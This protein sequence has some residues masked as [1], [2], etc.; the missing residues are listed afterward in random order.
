MYQQIRN[1]L[2]YKDLFIE[3]VKK[4]IKLKY[5]NSYLGLLWSFLNP[6]LMMT[7]LTIVF[8]GIFKNNIS[9][10]PVYVLSGRLMYSFFSEATSFAM[11]SIHVNGQLIKKVYIPKYF[12]PLS[13]V[14]SSFLTSL[15]SLVPIFLVMFIT[16]MQFSIFNLLIVVPLFLMLILSAGV[17]LLLSVGT[18]FFRDVGHLY[19][20]ILTILMYM[21]P[22]FY[23]ADIIPDK[24]Q[25]LIEI[26]PLY[27]LV[28][29]FRDVLMYGHNFSAHQLTISLIYAALYFI[30]GLFVFYKKQ[31]RFIFYL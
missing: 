13:R 24:Y 27:P 20:V 10:F 9:N 21:T 30:I 11:N 12:F 14:C 22:I 16:D 15:V 7:V 26:N 23:P 19:T 29:M 8:S 6:L 18:V 31:D 5:R 1:F 3:L 2:K 4:D 17:G 25:W 28:G